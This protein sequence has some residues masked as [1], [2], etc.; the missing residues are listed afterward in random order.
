MT[1][2]ATW[3]AKSSAELKQLI[4]GDGYDNEAVL[5]DWL[6]RHPAFVPGAQGPRGTTAWVP[7]PSALISQPP[8]TGINGRIPD[9][10]WLTLDSADLT[11]MLVEIEVPAKPWQ[12]KT[13][14]GQHAK[15]TQARDQLNSWRSWFADPTNQARFLDD[16][17]VPSDLRTHHRFRQH[18]VLIYGSRSEYEGDRIRQRG[19]AG[20]MSAPDETLM[21]FDRL[22]EIATAKAA[23]YGCVK[24][25]GEG[26]KAVA[27]PECWEPARVSGEALRLTVGYE[28]AIAACDDLGDAA[29]SAL[30][31]ELA[32]NVPTESPTFRFRPRLDVY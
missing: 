32:A 7:W 6:E 12:H 11:A 8:L 17:L 22:P 14:E 13:D 10:C 4:Q 1:D 23:R 30:L 24:R 29:R 31:A 25:R 27:I 3:I 18:Y 28:Q 5:Q 19:R 15:L 20:A 26:F 21:S 2:V 9:F 16:F